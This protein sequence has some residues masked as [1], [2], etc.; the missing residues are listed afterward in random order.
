[1]AGERGQDITS[2]FLVVPVP[3]IEVVRCWGVVV[4][5]CD[6]IAKFYLF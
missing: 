1:M 4:L 2:G 5:K 3:K 6:L